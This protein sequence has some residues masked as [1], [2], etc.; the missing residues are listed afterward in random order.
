MATV[1]TDPET[2]E[3]KSELSH[4]YIWGDEPEEEMDSQLTPEMAGRIALYLLNSADYGDFTTEYAAL[5]QFAK[6]EAAHPP[7]P[8]A[9]RERVMALLFKW[10]HGY[11]KTPEAYISELRAA[12]E[13]SETK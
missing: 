1:W 6:L 12:I 8:D 3:Y 5:E 13:G 2:G 7:A 11:Y 9:L 4:E 10:T